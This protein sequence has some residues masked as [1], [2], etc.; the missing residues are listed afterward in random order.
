M[1]QQNRI[2]LL[3]LYFGYLFSDMRIEIVSQW[4]MIQ[5]IIRMLM[6]LLLTIFGAIYFLMRE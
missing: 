6:A 2:G 1:K 5:D 3:L 4:S